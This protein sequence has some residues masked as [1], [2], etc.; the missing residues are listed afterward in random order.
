MSSKKGTRNPSNWSCHAVIRTNTRLHRKGVTS[1]FY[2]TLPY[3]YRQTSRTGTVATFLP[4]ELTVVDPRSVAK[5]LLI[6]ARSLRLVCVSGRR[7][8]RNES[9]TAAS[10]K[11]GTELLAV[12]Y[13]GEKVDLSGNGQSPVNFVGIVGRLSRSLIPLF[14]TRLC[15]LEIHQNGSYGVGIV[16]YPSRGKKI[17][18]D[19]GVAGP[20][21]G[22]ADNNVVAHIGGELSGKGID[23]DELEIVVFVELKA[24]TTGLYEKED[25]EEGDQWSECELYVGD[26]IQDAPEEEKESGDAEIGLNGDL[27]P[28]F[29]NGGCRFAKPG[30][31]EILEESVPRS[32]SRAVGPRPRRGSGAR[33]TRRRWPPGVDRHTREPQPQSPGKQQYHQCRWGTSGHYWRHAREGRGVWVCGGGGM[34]VVVMV[35]TVVGEYQ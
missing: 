8:R 33:P 6:G 29:R 35:T 20:S 5:S 13:G 3:N 34:L 9:S 24:Q 31:Q 14:G 23:R 32:V 17:V 1:N 30:S 19:E 7:R 27:V 28:F 2:P 15:F 12:G 21:V 4:L 11:F 10:F 25:T 26:G 18:I 16:I 22:S